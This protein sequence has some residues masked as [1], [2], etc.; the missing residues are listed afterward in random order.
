M[1]RDSSLT[2]GLRWEVTPAIKGNN[3]TDALLDSAFSCANV[4]MLKYSPEE[5]LPC[6][7]S[8]R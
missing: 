3:S 5:L 1:R 4:G 6:P 2:Y 7:R 8:I